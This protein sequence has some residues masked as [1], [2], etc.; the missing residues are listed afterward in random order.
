MIECPACGFVQALPPDPCS[1]CGFVLARVDGFSSWAPALAH[2]GGGF[3]AE[4]FKDLSRLEAENFWFQSRNALILWAV[5]KYFPNITS[6]MEVGCGT[7]YVMS[8]FS[9]AFPAARLVDSE[10]FTAGLGFAA[11]RAPAASFVQM[12]A[13]RIPYVDEF[14]VIAAFDVIEH[15]Q[16]DVVVLESLY[17]AVKPGGGILLAV[18]QHR[19][20]W[21]AA[22]D[23]ACHQ[24]RYGASELASK[25]RGVGFEVVRS[26]SFVSLL[27][28]AMLISR[29]ATSK[30]EFDPLDEF[31]IGR[32]LNTTLGLILGLE[33][34]LIR[35]GVN[36][37]LGGSRLIVGRKPG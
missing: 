7:G 35:A 12:D 29:R 18:P 28:P 37:P 24:R 31:R 9:R 13:R 32:A 4:Y 17:R 5:K 10:I 33:R 22:D 14:D 15:I 1:R 11:A 19:W 8:G 36:F 27:L 21:S 16:E 25:V 20:L 6:L 2:A 3:K 23:Y 26:T 30:N 34:L